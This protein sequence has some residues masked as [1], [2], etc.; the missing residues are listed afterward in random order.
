MRVA[1]EVQATNR[2]HIMDRQQ[3]L[4]QYMWAA[5]VCFQHP[6][7]GQQSTAVVKTLHPRRGGD[8]EVRACEAC[9]LRLEAERK[10]AARASGAASPG[11]DGD[12]ASPNRGDGRL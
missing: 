9:V 8:E 7:Y 2:R 11:S 5:G 1:P 12:E 4:D 6:A 10:Q 3:I